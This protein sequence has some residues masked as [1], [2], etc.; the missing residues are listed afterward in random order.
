V[1]FAEIHEQMLASGLIS[2]LPDPTQDIDDDD[3]D[4]LPVY[5]AVQLAAALEGSR[6]YQTG[7]LDPVTLLS[8]DQAL[9]DAAIAE[10]LTVEDPTIH[11]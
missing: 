5:D 9:N 7:G 2:Q 4:D 3:P 11:P 1:P 10:G 8:S 6:I